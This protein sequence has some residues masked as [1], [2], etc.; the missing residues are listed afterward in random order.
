MGIKFDLSA[1]DLMDALDLAIMI[2]ED[3]KERYDEFYRQIGTNG[4]DDAG[5]FF[6]QMAANEQKHTDDLL[7]LRKKH[8]NDAKSKV[9]RATLYE[10]QEI[11]APEFDQAESRMSVGKALLVA[12]EC[13]IKAHNFYSKASR[14][15]K[16]EEVKKFFNEL[17]EEEIE[18]QK[19]VKDIINKNKG[20]L[21]P[22][23]DSDD[24]DG[25]NGL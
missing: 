16:N 7:A 3:A 19:M 17:A 13:E 6:H 5:M 11:E 18:H 12:L 8:F 14:T 23:V 15:V 1:L 10:F 22:E 9:S 24:I 21:D 25:P 20:I 2:E 4:V